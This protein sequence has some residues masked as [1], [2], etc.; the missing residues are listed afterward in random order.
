MFAPNVE[1]V[2]QDGVPLR[3]DVSLPPRQRRRLPVGGG[4]WAAASAAAATETEGKVKIAGS[5]FMVS[6]TV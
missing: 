5:L 2:S 3:S 6:D 4:R 1:C